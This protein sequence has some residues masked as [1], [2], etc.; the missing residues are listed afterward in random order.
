VIQTDYPFEL[1]QH[2]IDIGEHK[3]PYGWVDVPLEKLPKPATTL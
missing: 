1:L 3:R 2:L